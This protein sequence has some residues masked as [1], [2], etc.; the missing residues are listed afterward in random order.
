[1]SL[2]HASPEKVQPARHKVRHRKV[3]QGQ[4]IFKGH[5]SW[6]IMMNIKLGLAV[7]VGRAQKA[8]PEALASRDFDAV[9]KQE[10]PPEGT[11]VTPAH[12][13]G[14]FSFKDH[15]PQA[16]RQI[17]EHFGV[18][19]EDYTI[20]LCGEHSMRELGTPG[21]SGSIF[22]L[23]EDGRYLQPGI[24]M[25][26]C[27]MQLTMLCYSVP[28]RYIIKTVSKQE[29]KF[30]RQML[31]NY[32][33]HVIHSSGTLLPR[34]FGLIRITT[35]ANRNIR[36]VVMNNLMPDDLPVHEKFDLKGSTLGRYATDAEKKDP[37]VTLKD[38]DFTQ[39]ERTLSLP[40]HLHAKV[41]HQLEVDCNLLRTL[42][43][44]DYSLFAML[45]FPS[46]VPADERDGDDPLGPEESITRSPVALR[47]SGVGEGSSRFGAG[48]SKNHA[49][50]E[51]DSEDS[52]H[53]DGNVPKLTDAELAQAFA[54]SIILHNLT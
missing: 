54:T 7:T 31:P 34:Y 32:Y 45:H 3:K 33:A 30:L 14:F 29:S 39:R 5:P 26:C 8:K 41:Q 40:A 2:M 20:S 22:Y 16:F 49:A 23:T 21:K 6:N 28:C 15:A 42:H 9:Y 11:S 36:M 53:W 13:A 50:D 10:F 43:I 44:M 19:E 37:N 47:F 12:V 4:T 25:L 27:T 51:G 35:A 48:S 24:A 46:R 52:D 1:M 17:R 18:R 38:L